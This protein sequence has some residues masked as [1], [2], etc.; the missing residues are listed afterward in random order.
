MSFLSLRSSELL[1]ISIQLSDRIIRHCCPAVAMVVVTVFFE[2][3]WSTL[4]SLSSTRFS[5]SRCG[6]CELV[7]FHTVVCE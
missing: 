1:I 4:I 3:L 6:L 5:L 2:S 7:N